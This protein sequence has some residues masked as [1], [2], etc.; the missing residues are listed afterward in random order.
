MTSQDIKIHSTEMLLCSLF[1]LTSSLHT[2]VLSAWESSPREKH[3]S[4]EKESN[5][6]KI[7]SINSDCALQGE[8]PVRTV[9]E[10][11]CG[12]RH[13]WDRRRRWE[14]ATHPRRSRSLVSEA[15]G[16][17]GCG[18]IQREEDERRE[19]PLLSSPGHWCAAIL[20][21]S[22]THISD[23]QYILFFF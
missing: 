14:D 8:G 13:K 16:G 20:P 18:E 12:S 21:G 4:I 23:C 11:K 19:E 7:C 5:P 17:A 2:A 9:W 10:D 3:S 1:F 15:A 6:A 22:Q